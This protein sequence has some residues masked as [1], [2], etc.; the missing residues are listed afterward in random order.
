VHEEKDVPKRLLA[1]LTPSAASSADKACE[2]LLNKT[3]N[4]SVFLDPE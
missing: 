2:L 3:L 1:R 4:Q